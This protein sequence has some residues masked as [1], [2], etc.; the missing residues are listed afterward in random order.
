MELHELGLTAARAT[1]IYVFLLVL[2]RLMGKRAVGKPTAFDFMV[3]LILGEL[4]DEPIY[5][6]VPVTGALTALAVIAG[7][8]HLNAY[9]SYRSARFDRLTGGRPRVLVRDGRPDRRAMAR[10]HINEEE[11][12]MMLRL[13]QVDKLEDVQCATLEPDGQLSVLPAAD[14]RPLARRDLPGLTRT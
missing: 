2:L 14:A 9:L 10:E 3:A 7:W 5:G 12:W 8:H 6:D 11:L 4:V 13:R 1:L